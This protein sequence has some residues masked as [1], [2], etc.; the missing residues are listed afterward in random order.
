V[1]LGLVQTGAHDRLIAAMDYFNAEPVVHTW[2]HRLDRLPDMIRFSKS[3][4]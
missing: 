3:V 1:H 2:T 4:G